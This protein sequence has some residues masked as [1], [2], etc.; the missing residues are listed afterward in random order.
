MIACDICACGIEGPR[1]TDPD[2]ANDYHPACVA[3]R[4]PEDALV[5]LLA[6]ATLVLAPTIV[7]WAG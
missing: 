2:T 7:V 3:K 5:A 4:V 6:A 1:L